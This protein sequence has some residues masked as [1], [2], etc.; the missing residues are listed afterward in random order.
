[1]GHHSGE[2]IPPGATQDDAATPAAA[3]AVTARI[4]SESGSTSAWN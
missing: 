4:C 1:M 3:S 2:V